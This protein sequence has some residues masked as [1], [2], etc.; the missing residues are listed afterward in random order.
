MSVPLTGNYKICNVHYDSNQVFDLQVGGHNPVLPIIGRRNAKFKSSQ[1]EIFWTLQV[2]GDASPEFKG[3]KVVRL[4]N[5]K[6]GTYAQPKE[7]TPSIG[8]HVVGAPG[9]VDWLLAPTKTIGQ[10]SIQTP[11]GEFACALLSR[12]DY[13]PV[14]LEPVDDEDPTQIWKFCPI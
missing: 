13:T 14:Q 1:T 7:E 3:Y 5:V 6:T 11:D 9:I 12:M 4:I 2:V 8:E 10:Y